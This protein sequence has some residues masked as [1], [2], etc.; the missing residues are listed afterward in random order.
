[1]IIINYVTET[2]VM[3]YTP[4]RESVFFYGLLWIHPGVHTTTTTTHKMK[5]SQLFFISFYP[6]C[7][8]A[9]GV[10]KICICFTYK[11]E[12]RKIKIEKKFESALKIL[13]TLKKD[14]NSINH[15]SFNSLLNWRI[16]LALLGKQ[17]AYQISTDRPA[18]ARWCWWLLFKLL[19]TLQ[20]LWIIIQANHFGRTSNNHHHNHHPNH[21]DQ[22]KCRIIE[23]IEVKFKLKWIRIEWRR[24][25]IKW[26][27]KHIRRSIRLIL[28]IQFQFKPKFTVMFFH[29]F[30]N[31]F[32]LSFHKPFFFWFN[33]IW[34][35][36]LYAMVPLEFLY[37]YSKGEPKAIRL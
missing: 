31:S 15:R 37:S 1:M 10:K 14:E 27:Q 21:H 11:Q 34:P 4:E 25:N 8:R 16:A 26:R 36:V 5:Q 24:R 2:H 6:A 12:K 20:R 9:I 35:S 17:A 22:F 33:L 3:G 13:K 23:G 7:P 18:Y 19:N 32:I 29:L 28:E 30:F